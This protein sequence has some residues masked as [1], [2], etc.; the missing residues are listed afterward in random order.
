MLLATVASIVV[1]QV[2]AVQQVVH[3][4]VL[5]LAMIVWV[6]HMAYTGLAAKAKDSVMISFLIGDSP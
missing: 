4:T 6:V 1:E 3:T 2:V 5:P